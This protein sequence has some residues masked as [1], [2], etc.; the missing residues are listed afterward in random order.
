L[1]R[2]FEGLADDGR[3]RARQIPFGRGTRVASREDLGT[4]ALK[5][6][7]LPLYANKV[8]AIIGPSGCG[9]STLLRVLNRIYDI[10]PGQ[11]AT[12]EVIFDGEN[13]LSPDCDV[14][15]LRSRIGMVFQ[16]PTPFPMS[17]Y[18][19]IAFGIRLYERL[20]RFKLDQRVELTLRQA[21]LWDEVKNNL[22]SN[23]QTRSLRPRSRN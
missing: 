12:G 4:Q 10:Y 1:A 3:A 15:S 11:R 5:G 19:N 18:E 23:G 14:N 13:I 7:N 22:G 20:P 9:K 21:A 8:T 16:R 2:L 17:I 6:I